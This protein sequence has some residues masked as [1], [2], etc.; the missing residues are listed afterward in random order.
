MLVINSSLSILSIG[1][2]VARKHDKITVHVTLSYNMDVGHQLSRRAIDKIDNRELMTNIHV[3]GEGHMYCNLTMSSCHWK[4]NRQNT[5]S[6]NM[7]V[8]HQLFIIYFVYWSSS[9]KKTW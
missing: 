1:L 6:H 3:V 8:G 7:D 5:L 2:P 4:T 9:G